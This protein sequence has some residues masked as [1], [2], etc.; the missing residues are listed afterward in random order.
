MNKGVATAVGILLLACGGGGVP[1]KEAQSDKPDAAA[2]LVLDAGDIEAQLQA[3]TAGVD[4][5]VPAPA[6]PA[7]PALPPSPP[8]PPSPP[9][10]C[11][12]AGVDFEK[13]ARPKLKE[14]Y[15]EG[16][17]KDPN[18]EGTVRIAIKIDTL[19]KVRS[20]TIADKTLPDQVAKCMLDV[21]K[22]TPFTEASKCPGKDI[23]IPMAFPTQ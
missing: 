20:I 14:C 9:D 8:S 16:K 3:L 5:G 1:P 7:A 4:L 21:V 10:E 19:G 13:R 12:P 23:T 18:L 6:A 2:F 11:V 15:R 22:K 17:R